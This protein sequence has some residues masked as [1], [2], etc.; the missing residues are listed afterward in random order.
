MAVQRLHGPLDRGS[1]TS[2]DFADDVTALL[3]Q[4]QPAESTVVLYGDSDD[5]AGVDGRCHT[6]TGRGRV[7]REFSGDVSDSDRLAVACH[8]IGDLGDVHLMQVDEAGEVAA[9]LPPSQGEQ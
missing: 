8:D 5:N 3:G 4:L 9:P 2:L 6:S 1:S 7:D